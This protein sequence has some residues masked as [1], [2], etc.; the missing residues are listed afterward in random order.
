MDKEKYMIHITSEGLVLLS[1]VTSE[2]GLPHYLYI[3][4]TYVFPSFAIHTFQIS[5][6]ISEKSCCRAE[7]C[8]FR[9]LIVAQTKS[10]KGNNTSTPSPS[11]LS[12]A[13][14]IEI[15]RSTNWIT[16]WN[17]CKIHWNDEVVSISIAR[18]AVCYCRWSTHYSS[19]CFQ[20]R[21][22]AP[23]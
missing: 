23:Q 8:Y 17:I 13:A 2:L 14:T 20:P 3:I 10:N 6:E 22:N 19:V 12:F 11:Y 18:M 21:I 4:P 5:L 9:L 1:D 15:N 16:G 7:I